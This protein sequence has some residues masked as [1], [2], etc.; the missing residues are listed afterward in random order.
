MYQFVCRISSLDRTSVSLRKGLMRCQ[1]STALL[2]SS[3]RQQRCSQASDSWPSRG[4]R[5]R[6]LT[7]YV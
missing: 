7:S 1:S 5:S 6:L 4:W 2:E 3:E